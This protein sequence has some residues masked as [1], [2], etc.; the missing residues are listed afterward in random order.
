MS[1]IGLFFRLR[2]WKSSLFDPITWPQNSK[3]CIVSLVEEEYL[4]TYFLSVSTGVIKNARFQIPLLFHTQ[5]SIIISCIQVTIQESERCLPYQGPPTK[6]IPITTRLLNR[7]TRHFPKKKKREKKKETQRDK[8]TMGQSSPAVFYNPSLSPL[9]FSLTT[10][11][12]FISTKGQNPI[13]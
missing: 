3:V 7:K 2:L 9:Y 1:N 11:L 8:S 12:N 10:F 13:Y 5:T 6:S 4:G